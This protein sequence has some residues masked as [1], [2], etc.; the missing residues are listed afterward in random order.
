MIRIGATLASSKLKKQQSDLILNVKVHTFYHK[1]KLRDV[2]N[3]AHSSLPTWIPSNMWNISFHIISWYIY[4]YRH[5]APIASL[6]QSWLLFTVR[7]ILWSKVML[8]RR[9]WLCP[10]L[11]WSTFISRTWGLFCLI[12]LLFPKHFCQRPILPP[13][14]QTS[15]HQRKTRQRSEFCA[16][17]TRMLTLLKPGTKAKN[18]SGERQRIRPSPSV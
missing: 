6:G 1:Q 11:R 7:P 4:S 18:Q 2:I 13:H 10:L 15:C 17:G 12:V 14:P 3:S 16:T 9:T 8:S 5:S